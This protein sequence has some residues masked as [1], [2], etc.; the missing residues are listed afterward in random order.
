M[1]SFQFVHELIT[2]H[3]FEQLVKHR[4]NARVFYRRTSWLE[5]QNNDGISVQVQAEWKFCALPG[6]P[7]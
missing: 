4:R 5:L 3:V 7:E 1:T 2:A 6:A